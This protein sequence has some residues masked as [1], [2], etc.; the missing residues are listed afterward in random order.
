MLAIVVAADVAVVIL[1]QPGRAHRAL[2]A[3]FAAVQ[4]GDTGAA[5][6]MTT[7]AMTPA[8]AGV[9]NSRPHFLA[10]WRDHPIGGY[11]VDEAGSVTMVTMSFRGGTSREIPIRVTDD[12]IEYP[13]EVRS[14]RI[15]G[16]PAESF[17]IDGVPV[18][19]VQPEP[20]YEGSFLMQPRTY[21]LTYRVTVL[22]GPHTVEIP[23]GEWTASAATT[24]PQRPDAAAPVFLH[25]DTDLSL[26]PNE[27]AV[28]AARETIAAFAA[29]CRPRDGVTDGCG[30]QG[31]RLR[32]LV[33]FEAFD[34]R[35]TFMLGSVETPEYACGGLIV[36]V[37][38][39]M[40]A[41][42]WA[43]AAEGFAAG[44][45]RLRILTIVRLPP[46]GSPRLGVVCVDQLGCDRVADPEGA[47]TV[48]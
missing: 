40:F 30:E 29:G 12:G 9:A 3:F 1:R 27:R 22:A 20:V 48:P 41:G 42:E 10:L 43:V 14:I 33:P 5:Y 35:R 17:L 21:T 7:H 19:V 39:P 24:L 11:R 25:P 46:G 15:R 18:D 31:A 26:E 6:E 28:R 2:D 13:L 8:A 44:E 4:R 32:G 45:E 23:P 16:G 38:P 36:S 37:C 47:G 34:A